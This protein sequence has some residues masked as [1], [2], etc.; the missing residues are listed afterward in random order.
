M[1]TNDIKVTIQSGGLGRLP[2]G[3]DYYTGIIFQNASSPASWDASGIEV[4]YS[5]AE[6][7]DLGLTSAL[8]PVE[9]YHITEF[10]RLMTKWQ[11]NGVL[12]V[13]IANIT[14]TQFAGTEIGEIQTAAEGKLRQIGVFLTD[15]YTDGDLG[16]C[17]TAAVAL[18]TAGTPA[19]IL[20]A[21]DVADYT[22][23]TDA[24]TLSSKW[25][26]P[27]LAQ[28]G[29]GT[30]SDLFTSE[31]YSI[32][33]IGAALAALAYAKVHESIGW[34]GKFDI[35]G[36]TELQTLALADGTLISTLTDAALSAVAD[37]G[38]LIAVKRLVSGSYFYDSPTAEAATSDFAYIETNRTI[39]KAKRLLL[40]S[41]APLQNSPLYVNAT[42]GKLSEQTIA[43]FE[44]KGIQALNT[45]A[46][47]GEIS[48]DD[49]T[50]RI[51]TNSIQINPDQNVLSTS[52]IVILIR[53][54]PV[55]VARVIEVSLSFAV[56][57]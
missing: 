34:V 1:F 14:A 24:R 6:A 30:G 35:S 26:T 20:F 7:E 17:Q 37:D 4:L 12:Y 11:I 50:G 2:A 49:Q 48:V 36:A 21:A 28:D 32:T 16:D 19:S 46:Q 23:L 56:S 5:V 44:A 47:A 40:Q 10:F 43:T 51:P 27:V 45:M 57:V 39:A 15:P 54:V 38:Y 41:F 31:G 42:T 53:L 18:D 55:G 25:V 29:A 33:C 52:K 3:E 8:F 22:A 13:Y 9:H